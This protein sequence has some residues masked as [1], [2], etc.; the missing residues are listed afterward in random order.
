MEIGQHM[1]VDTTW[2]MNWIQV[3]KMW[4]GDEYPN[5]VY[6]EGGINGSNVDHYTQVI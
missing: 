4:G 5:F 2:K 6:G 3:M 1:Y